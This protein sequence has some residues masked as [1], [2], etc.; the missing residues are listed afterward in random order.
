M[1]IEIQQVRPP[2]EKTIYDLIMEYGMQDLVS[3]LKAFA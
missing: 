2:L 3:S 1:N